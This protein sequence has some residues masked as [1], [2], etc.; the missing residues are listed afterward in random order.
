MKNVGVIV[1]FIYSQYRLAIQ[2]LNFVTILETAGYRNS[3]I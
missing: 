3:K 1:I 2:H